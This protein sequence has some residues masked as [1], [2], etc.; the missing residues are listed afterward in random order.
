MAASITSHSFPCT[1]PQPLAQ[2]IYNKELRTWHR[3]ALVP[4]LFLLAQL[5]RCLHCQVWILAC[6][7]Q[8]PRS[9]A[10]PSLASEPGLSSAPSGALNAASVPRSS[11]SGCTQERAGRIQCSSLKIK[12]AFSTLLLLSQLYRA[13]QSGPRYCHSPAR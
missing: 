11:T 5:D 2:Y 1:C 4:Q 7:K 9:L 3:V 13:E 8:I 6:P 12:H 10:S